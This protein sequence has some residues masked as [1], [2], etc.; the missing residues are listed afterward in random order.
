MWKLL[1][2]VEKAEFESFEALEYAGG[3]VHVPKVRRGILLFLADN[4]AWSTACFWLCS[5]SAPVQQLHRKSILP[6]MSWCSLPYP[7]EVTYL[8]G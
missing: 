1:K 3:Q 7:G 5:S 8:I 6:S 2:W 4:R